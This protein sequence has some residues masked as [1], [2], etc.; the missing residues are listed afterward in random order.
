MSE[1]S[2]MK[3][4]PQSILLATDLSARSDRSLDRAKLLAKQWQS[5]LTLLH[6]I[7]DA[8]L[9]SS[10]TDAAPSWRRPPD[11]VKVVKKH[12]VEDLSEEG[13]SVKVLVQEGAVVETIMRV[14]DRESSGLIVI[15]VARNE[16]FG[17]L[18]LGR[19]VDRL[20]RRSQVPLL[21]VKNRPRR[22]Y[23]KIVVATDFSDSS[24]N[25]LVSAARFFPKQALTI[26]HAYDAPMSQRMS[27]AADYR[28][29]RRKVAERD[30]EAFLEATEKPASWQQP[31]ILLE[32]GPPSE[33]LSEYVFENAAD[34]V[35]V[36]THGRSAVLDMLLGSVA[37][38][39][40]NDVPCDI[41]VIREPLAKAEG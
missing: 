35:V 2:W 32:Y 20:L 21:V 38:Q 29:E 10:S 19:T 40:L 26:F 31:E 5:R 6:V 8:R 18:S 16:I 33:L 36:S 27:D 41:L 9:L 4:P 23:R 13:D 39:I 30:C 22:P 7:E 28:R 14:T 37:K 25:A 1:Q 15:G 24:R 11:P 12:I 17:E 3:G 34:L